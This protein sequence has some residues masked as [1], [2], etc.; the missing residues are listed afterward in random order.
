M[1][2]ESEVANDPSQTGVPTSLLKSRR[3]FVDRTLAAIERVE[4]SLASA[5][6]GRQRQWLSE[7]HEAVAA[8]EEAMSDQSSD[9]D[10][11]NGLMAEIERNEPRL[12]HQVQRL[13]REYHELRQQLAALRSQLDPS[14]QTTPDYAQIRE[15]VGMLLAAVRHYRG[16]ENDLVFEA[17]EIDLGVGD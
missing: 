3:G 2:K 17:Y 16:R 5:A 11:E 9:T 8:L 13:R 7:V 6:P 4:G 1:G 12:S 10:D 14:S 15:R